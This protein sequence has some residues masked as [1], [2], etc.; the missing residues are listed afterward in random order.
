MDVMA[1]ARAAAKL[2]SEVIAAVAAVMDSASVVGDSGG[3][4]T[5]GLCWWSLRVPSEESIWR[6]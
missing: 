2:G 5:A 3:C 4:V 1:A 6:W